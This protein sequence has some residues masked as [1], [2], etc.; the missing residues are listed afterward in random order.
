MNS[1]WGRISAALAPRSRHLERRPLDWWAI[2]LTLLLCVVWGV[3][4]TAMKMVAGDVD[5][6][7]KL[8][9]PFAVAALFFGFLTWRQEGRAAFRDGTLP[10]GLLLGALFSLE[11]ML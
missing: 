10:S 3:Q 1:R 11:F 8:G 2:G 6:I 5:Q 7:M 4:Q 9:I